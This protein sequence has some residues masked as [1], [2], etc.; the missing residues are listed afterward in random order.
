MELRRAYFEW[1]LRAAHYKGGASFGLFVE[2]IKRDAMETLTEA[3]KGA[4]QATL[5]ALPA[6]NAPAP[7]REARPIVRKWTLAE[8][9]AIVGQGLQGRD[10]DRGRALFAT[11]NCFACH[12]YDNEGGAVGPDLTQLA[13]R[14]SPRDILESVVEPS[15]VV[16]DQ[17]LAVTIITEDG[18]SVTGRIINLAGNNMMVNT[19]M[20]DP[21]AITAVDARLVESITPS[22]VSMM[23]EGLLDV[24]H[25]DEVR[26][27][28]AYLLSRGNREHAM[29]KK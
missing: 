13:G 11:A 28:L 7:P 1:F 3:E 25:E 8:L 19:N 10:F 12:R 24:L 14:F 23:P 16:S 2:N 27:L 4:L 15:K 17:Y 9:V 5:T 29:F 22:K 26:D 18:K 6:P 21:N 20:L